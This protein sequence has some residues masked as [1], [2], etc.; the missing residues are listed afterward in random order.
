MQPKHYHE[1]GLV[2]RRR[3][4][5][6]G[7]D[8]R[9]PAR[10]HQRHMRAAERRRL[11]RLTAGDIRLRPSKQLTVS[12]PRRGPSLTFSVRS[13]LCD[14]WRR[15]DRGGM[16][17]YG[18]AALSA[19]AP[20]SPSQ[21]PAGCRPNS[22]TASASQYSGLRAGSRRG[23]GRSVTAR[24]SSP[25]TFWPASASGRGIARALA[26]AGSYV[27]PFHPAMARSWSRSSMFGGGLSIARISSRTSD[28]HACGC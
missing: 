5:G 4:S 18:S 25:A 23:S 9:R 8:V 2:D 3:L 21:G 26:S 24:R 16:S 17:R 15:G 11:R 6:L 13:Q 27:P 1:S 28:S 22:G 10:T 19:F 20:R 12:W 7:A 14:V